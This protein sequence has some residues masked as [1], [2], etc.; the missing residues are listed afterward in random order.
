MRAAMW[1]NFQARCLALDGKPI[2]KKVAQEMLR[3]SRKNYDSLA[4][5]PISPL[6]ERL[7]FGHC[8]NDS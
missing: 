2:D 5:W 3:D 1:W 6:V 4:N 7:E 8:C